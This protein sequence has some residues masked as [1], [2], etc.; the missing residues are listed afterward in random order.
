[1]GQ[2]TEAPEAVIEFVAS[3]GTCGPTEEGSF[4]MTP[5]AP[6]RTDI[7]RLMAVRDLIELRDS[8]SNCRSRLSRFSWDYHGEPALLTR[9]DIE[10]VLK[11]YLEGR[12]N[13]DDLEEWAD[14]LEL[15]DDVGYEAEHRE[16]L[17]FVLWTL[18][19]QQLNGQIS[20]TTVLHLLSLD[21]Q[22]V[23]S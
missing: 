16:W 6:S 10:V 20:A 14:L 4:A 1:M 15:R 9:K 18:A 19:D 3:R 8:L 5:N 12:I 2:G 7:E 13:S 21:E 17:N 11:S 23:A 22:S